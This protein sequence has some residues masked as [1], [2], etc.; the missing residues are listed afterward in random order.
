MKEIIKM[1]KRMDLEYSYGVQEVSILENLEM[2]KG[3]EKVLC[4][5]LMVLCIQENGRMGFRMVMDN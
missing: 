1:I 2:M 5:G 3:M 4:I